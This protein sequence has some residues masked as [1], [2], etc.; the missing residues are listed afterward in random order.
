MVSSTSPGRGTRVAAS[1]S[2]GGAIFIEGSARGTPIRREKL[3][4]SGGPRGSS[5]YPPKRSRATGLCGPDKHVIYLCGG[6]NYSL[7]GWPVSLGSIHN[8]PPSGGVVVNCINELGDEDG[9]DLGDED[10]NEL[11]VGGAI[12]S[13]VVPGD[14]PFHRFILTT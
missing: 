11:E 12:A 3:S 10:G 7:E 14:R 6:R 1:P 4:K 2:D 5:H 9:N 13:S 8:D